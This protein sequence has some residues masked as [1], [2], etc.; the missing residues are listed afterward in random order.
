MAAHEDTPLLAVETEPKSTW[1]ERFYQFRSSKT[2]ISFVV[3]LALFADMV[4]YGIVVPIL[5]LIAKERLNADPALVGLL[6]GTYAFGLLGSTPVFAILSDRYKTRKIPMIIG[7]LGLGVSTI[8]FIVAENFWQLMLARMAQGA[9][10]GASWTIGLTMIADAYPPD[11]LGVAMGVALSWNGVGFLV[12]PAIGGILFQYW[13]FAAPFVFC[14]A[15]AFIDLLAQLLVIPATP[16]ESE[17]ELVSDTDDV[18][19][20]PVVRVK[21]SIWTMIREWPIIL[22]SLATFLIASNYSSIEPTLGVFLEE[23]F[24]YD[25]ST[26]GVI[27]MALV[28]PNVFMSPIAGYLS[29]RFGGMNISGLGVLAFA[30]VTPLIALPRSFW[31][32][33]LSLVLCG[34][35]G[36]TAMTPILPEMG[37]HVTKLGGGAFAQVYAI[38]NMAYSLG[39]LFGPIAGG[40]LMKHFGFF[41]TMLT[42]GALLL[43]FAPVIIK[44]KRL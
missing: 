24:H 9:A 31:L 10:G 44:N 23:E 22:C 3:S 43:V 7:L 21:P 19:S 39:M 27:Y 35:A 20:Q 1:N 4:V 41:R 8:F 42:F 36:A 28:I 26:I 15:L 25:A 29:S 14:A 40:Y 11:Q 2:A 13:G 37:H 6:F 33:S 32:E 12:G 38:F 5:P 18:E 30:L 16:K 34:A 17:D